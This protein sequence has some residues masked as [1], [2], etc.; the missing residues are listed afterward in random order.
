VRA[1]AVTPGF[2]PLR[3]AMQVLPELAEIQAIEERTKRAIAERIMER[4]TARNPDI[5]E[6]GGRRSR[7]P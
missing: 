3:R 7:R 6:A 1:V 2:F 5:G 4:L